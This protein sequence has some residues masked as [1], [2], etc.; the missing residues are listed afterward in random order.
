MISL[1][2]TAQRKMV[3]FLIDGRIVKYFD[4]TWKGGIQILPSQT[5][6]MRLMLKKMLVSRKESIK[7]VGA[8]IVDANSG[9]NKK[10]YDSCKTEEDIAKMI[11]KDCLTKGLV[12]VRAK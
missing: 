7:M 11:R 1:I 4:D 2:F 8:L 9:E 5:P 3:R 6:E 12:E 10:E